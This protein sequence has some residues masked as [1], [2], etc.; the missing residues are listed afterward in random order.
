MSPQ[1]ATVD[2][3]EIVQVLSPAISPIYGNNPGYGFLKIDLD[4]KTS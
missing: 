2:N 1:S 4:Q 3:L